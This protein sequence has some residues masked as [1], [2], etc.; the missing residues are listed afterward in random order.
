MRTASELNDSGGHRSRDDVSAELDRQRLGVASGR[1]LSVNKPRRPQLQDSTITI[2]SSIIYTLLI[3]TVPHQHYSTNPWTPSLHLPLPANHP[4]PIP[5]QRRAPPTLPP[6]PSATTPPGPP[7]T[8]EPPP[9]SNDRPRQH[10]HN[11]HL[12]PNNR[13]PTPAATTPTTTISTGATTP[14]ISRT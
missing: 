10:R 2:I 3:S 9:P 13:S 11:H 7:T 12:H 1:T 5:I 8:A 6:T 14:S 4:S